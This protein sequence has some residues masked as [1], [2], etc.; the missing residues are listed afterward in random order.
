MKNRLLI[1]Y[2]HNPQDPCQIALCR[3]AGSLGED[4]LFY[5]LRAD[6]RKRGSPDNKRLFKRLCAAVEKEKPT[7]IFFWLPYCNL[8][9]I[10]WLKKKG[11]YTAAATNGVANF[12][13]G[14]VTDQK[15]YFELLR[16]LDAYFIPHGPHVAL[17]RSYGIKAYEM[18]FFY[19]PGVYHPLPGWSRLFGMGDTDFIFIGNFGDEGNLQRPHRSGL[20]R[21]LAKKWPVRLVSDHRV[22]GPGIRWM[23]P[24]NFPPVLNWLMNKSRIILCF[25]YFPDVTVYN[26]SMTNVFLPYGDRERF[27]I[28]SRQFSA[29]GTGSAVMVERHPEIERFFEDKKEIIM[30]SGIEEAVSKSEYYLSHREELRRLS[31]VGQQKVRRLHTAGVRARQIASIMNGKTDV[32]S[33]TEIE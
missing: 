18:P 20:V 12:S 10:R 3:H 19:D 6:E 33:C 22:D 2:K 11:I 15:E 29:M 16:G 14:I 21:E 9:D 26:R 17:L 13:S 25:D 7:H 32:S 1:V 27:T 31:Y 8:E 24:I 4:P 23:K 28:R 30:W 5:R